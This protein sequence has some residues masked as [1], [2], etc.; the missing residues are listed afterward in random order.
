[1]QTQ[2]SPIVAY[3]D[4]WTSECIALICGIANAGGGTL[5]IESS[6]KAYTTGR[7]K[8]RRPFEQIPKLVEKELGLQ[9]TTEP[10]LDG[11]A[12]CLETTVPAAAKPLAYDG[13]YW[14]Y[15]GNVNIRS[16]RKTI[17]GV[18]SN[19]PGD[20][21]S[22]D[23]PWEM[24][25]QTGVK[26]EDLNAR[27]FLTVAALKTETS[28]LPMD[29]LGAVF[30]HRLAHLNLEDPQ[31]Q[32]ITNAGVLLLHNQPDAII[33]GALVQLRLLA[34]DER[35]VLHD[36]V[37]G[38]LLRQIKETSRLLFEQYLPMAIAA[39][40][41]MNDPAA[42]LNFPS[43]EAVREALL[44]ALAHKDYACGQP[45]GV[46]V[47]PSRMIIRNPT[48]AGVPNLATGEDSEA[49][50]IVANPVLT[51]AMRLVG[52]MDD[53]DVDY[54]RIIQKNLE[55]GLDAP[56]LEQ[57]DGETSIT[58]PLDSEKRRQM[59]TPPPAH[60]FGSESPAPASRVTN[61]ANIENPESKP[62][63]TPFSARSI[64][65][66]NELDLTSTDEYVLRVLHTNGRA[67][68]VRIANVLGVSESTVR[69]AFRKLKKHGLIDR[70][71]SDKAGYWHVNV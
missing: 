17:E 39:S 58:F 12:L 63:Y 54:E 41:S 5:V 60:D 2:S 4:H 45:V 34:Q 42:G 22:F 7:R 52:I 23:T 24:R 37:S 56:L 9:C 38:P 26:L 30:E 1:M 35:V 28:D 68:A 29:P 48:E 57:D 59:S 36:E 46:D 32:A 47:F 44:G 19:A 69:R 64:A 18:L 65:A 10:V 25:P 49:P 67:T 66:A 71:G 61:V 21:G 14:L 62:R 53:R 33:P 13:T 40:G 27:V 20:T 31:T 51:R 16:T 55:V 15:A 70:I 11:T 6:E 50:A 8:L 3:R 43:R